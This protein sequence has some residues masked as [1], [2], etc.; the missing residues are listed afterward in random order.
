MAMEDRVDL[1]QQEA[2]DRFWRAM[3]AKALQKWSAPHDG[4]EVNLSDDSAPA[5]AGKPERGPAA[6]GKPERGPAG[7]RFK[8][9]SAS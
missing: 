8:H 7:A 4:A 3:I 6:A 9:Q 2:F 5:A 1:A